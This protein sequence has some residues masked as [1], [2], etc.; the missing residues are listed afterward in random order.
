MTACQDNPKGAVVAHIYI[1]GIPSCSLIEPKIH[2]RKRK[3]CLVLNIQSTTQGQQSHGYCRRL[4]NHNL[5]N[6]YHYQ[7]YFN[8]YPTPT[9]LNSPISVFLYPSSRE[10]FFA[11]DRDC[12]RKLQ[13]MCR[14]SNPSPSC[15]NYKTT[16][17]LKDQR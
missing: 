10:L 9:Y 5:L 6:Q 7:L 4:Y 11:K 2:S 12:Y 17:A 14:V 13:S 3:P 15:Y 8:N 16:P 1:L